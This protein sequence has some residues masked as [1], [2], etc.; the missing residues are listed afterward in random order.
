M[1]SINLPATQINSLKPE[2][3]WCHPLLPVPSFLNQKQWSL[4]PSLSWFEDIFFFISPFIF[5][6]QNPFVT[7]AFQIWILQAFAVF[8]KSSV[9]CFGWAFSHFC[10]NLQHSSSHVRLSFSSYSQPALGAGTGS[11]ISVCTYCVSSKQLLSYPFSF[12]FPFLWRYFH[13]TLSLSPRG[14]S[15]KLTLL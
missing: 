10:F 2:C 15:L 9:V 12:T 7:L 14:S 3:L 8:R 11:V 1:V 4:A 6:S 13:F 5:P